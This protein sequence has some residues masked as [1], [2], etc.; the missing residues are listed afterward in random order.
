MSRSTPEV[1]AMLLVL[2]LTT[3]KFVLAL[4]AFWMLLTVTNPTDVLRFG[5]LFIALSLPTTRSNPSA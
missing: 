4:W 3:S 5:L 2:V 1:V